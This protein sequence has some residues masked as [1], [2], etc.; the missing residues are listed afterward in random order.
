MSKLY[1]RSIFISDVHLGTRSCKA[2][3]L[4]NFLRSTESE[5]LYLVGDI[6][7]LLAMKKQV[8]WTEEQTAVIQ[9]VL[10]I[11]K[12]GTNVIY[13]PGNHDHFFRGFQNLQVRG[14]KIQRDAI[15]LTEKNKRL[16]VSHGDEF[17]AAVKH[18]KLIYFIGDS[19]Y[20][21]LLQLNHAN[22][23]IRNYLDLPYWSLSTFIKSKSKKADQFINSFKQAALNKAK[24]ENYDGY[25]C[26]HIHKS[27]IT[28]DGNVLYCNAGDW[29]EHCT[30]LIEDNTGDLQILHWSDHATIEIINKNT[31]V[32]HANIPLLVP[33]LGHS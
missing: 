25:V 1:F 10:N 19:A 22:N 17:D 23:V 2:A 21:F 28:H 6:F 32:L 14:I 31:E 27:G 11:A 12:S 26:G 5:Y 13:L 4:L 3:Y 20:N 16:F 30:A 24:S 7:D 9:E 15:H 18:S 8:Y 33:G 29:V